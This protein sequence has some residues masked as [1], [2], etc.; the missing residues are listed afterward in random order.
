MPFVEAKLRAVYRDRWVRTA[1]GSF[2]DDRQRT[3]GDGSTIEWDAHSLLTVMWDQ[4]NAI[5]RHDLSHSERSMVSELREY[6]NRWAHQ[7]QFDFDDTFRILDSARRLLEAVK[8]D[9][10]AVVKS[11][12]DAL[13]ES[14]VADQVNTQLQRS[15]FK[16]NRWWVVIVYSFCCMLLISFMLTYGNTAAPVVVAFITLLFVYL[17]YQQFKLDPPLLYG[18]REC[19]RCHR[20]IYRRTCPYCHPAN[21]PAHRRDRSRSGTQ[22][23]HGTAEA[24]VEARGKDDHHPGR[25]GTPL[26]GNREG[27]G[28]CPP[29]DSLLAE[30]VRQTTAEL[31]VPEIAPPDMRVSVELALRSLGQVAE[32]WDGWMLIPADHPTLETQVI[33]QLIAAWDS[34]RTRIAVPTW[35]GRRGHPTLFPG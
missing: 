7:Q 27:S 5:F 4:W 24:A 14:Y 11:E 34:D 16:R 29:D 23:P 10:V 13:I 8:A 32:A 15:A 33:E 9:N 12:R 3:A 17:I 20:I 31:V 1:L 26:R 30:E 28:R 2:R 18:P 19:Q 21:D 25:G 22:P 35:Q 6:R